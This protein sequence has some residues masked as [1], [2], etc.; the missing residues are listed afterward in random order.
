[1][2]SEMCIRD[3][4]M[5]TDEDCARQMCCRMVAE[6]MH[7]RFR[8]SR[9]LSAAVQVVEKEV[10][11]TRIDSYF[12]VAVQVAEKML[13]REFSR[14]KISAEQVAEKGL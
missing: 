7:H 1:M 12:S 11:R 3:R 8:G 4:D 9:A 14:Y 2:G 6:R 13:N 5:S 10:V